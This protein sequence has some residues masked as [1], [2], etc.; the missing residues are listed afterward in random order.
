[1]TRRSTIGT[2]PLWADTARPPTRSVPATANVPVAIAPSLRNSRRFMTLSWGWG[3][4]PEECLRLLELGPLRVGLGRE[5]HELCIVDAGL[6]TVAGEL[7]RASGAVNPVEPV[8]VGPLRGLELL[9]GLARLAHLEQHLTQ[10]LAGR[11]DGARRDGVLLGRILEVG[12]GAHE[13]HRLLLLPLG[14]RGP[15]GH[16]AAL[17]PPLLRP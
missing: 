6:L 5:A 4:P 10:Q 13:G 12:G 3:L 14:H 15:R 9:E 7:G 2:A 1:M 17:T 8:G 16:R 11:L